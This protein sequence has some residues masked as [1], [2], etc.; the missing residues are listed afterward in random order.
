MEQ[1]GIH[2]QKDYVRLLPHTLYKKIN[3]NL[4]HRAET[5]KLLEVNVG[6][7]LLDLGLGS[8]SLDITSKAQVTKR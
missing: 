2:M 6:I 4:D 3:S 7:N 5:T 1:L 8:G